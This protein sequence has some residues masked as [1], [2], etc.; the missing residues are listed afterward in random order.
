M[1]KLILLIFLFSALKIFS[2][3]QPV[4]SG[5]NAVSASGSVSYSIGQIAYQQAIGTGGSIIQG[6]QQPFEITAT[7]GVENSEIQLEMQVYPNPVSDILNLKIE[8][9]SFKNMQFRLYDLSG[10]LVK[11]ESIKTAE[12]KIN[13]QNFP[14][15]TYLLQIINEG[16]ISK[17]FKIIKK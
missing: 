6:M 9:I 12:T 4:S 16:K 7:L 17:I 11:T 2:Q 5:G 15:S 13:L 1:K 14:S 8:K 10:K 3:Q